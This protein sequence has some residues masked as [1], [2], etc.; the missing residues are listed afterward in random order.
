[1]LAH[2]GRCGPLRQVRNSVDPG[3]RLGHPGEV[4]DHHD[5]TRSAWEEASQKHVREHDE[6]LEEARHARFA[7][8]ERDVLA[9]LLASGPRVLHPQSGHGVDD[10]ALVRGGARSVLGLDYSPT[11]VGAAQRR[12]DALALPCWYEVAELPPFPVPTASTD[13]VYT[14]K[15]ALGWMR[16][17]PAWAREVRRVL[18]PGG[19]LFVLEAHPLVPLWTWEPDEARV[20]PD[21]SYFARENVNDS[22]PAGGAVE[23]QHTFGEVVMGVVGAGLEL[24]HL[25]EHPEP[26]WHPGGGVAA[27]W[28]GRLPNTF[29][30]LARAPGSAG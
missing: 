18:R 20:R 26:F 27:A 9:P 14:G 15:G 1:M 7:G 10:A 19:H 30:L 5:R 6:L 13:L 22:F 11:A 25:A 16:D 12:A 23:T 29:T 17:L 4:T 2:G 24:L 21:R 8:V 3:G 28:D